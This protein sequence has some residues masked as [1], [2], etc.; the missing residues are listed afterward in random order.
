MEEYARQ[1][2]AVLTVYLERG[3]AALHSLEA[4]RPDEA[5]ALLAKRTEA[6][7]NF[8]ALDARAAAAGH[9]LGRDP[10][11]L[12]LWGDIRAVDARL[13]TELEAAHARAAVIY[14]KVREARRTLG[15][16][17]SGGPATPR[18]EKTA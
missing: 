3:R 18:F 11:A 10:G 13:K 14:H 7:H 17:R 5:A 16:Y 9:E 15:S 12:A 8:R 6:F 1:A 4:G 2:R